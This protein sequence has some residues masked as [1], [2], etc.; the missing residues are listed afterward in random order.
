M[1]RKV[2]VIEVVDPEANE[3]EVAVAG[4][5]WV[6]YYEL[7]EGESIDD[8]MESYGTFVDDLD[9]LHE[10]FAEWVEEF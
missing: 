6:K 8:A 4:K 10:D 5:F 3:E 9:F 7:E 1:P 2:C